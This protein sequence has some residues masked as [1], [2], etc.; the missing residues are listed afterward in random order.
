MANLQAVV[1]WSAVAF[2]VYCALILLARGARLVGRRRTR[3][4]FHYRGP[5]RDH[6]TPT[7]VFI[8]GDAWTERRQAPDASDQL[9]A[10]TEAEFIRKRVMN[11]GEFRVFR[12]IEQ[13]VANGWHG[14]RVLSQTALGEVIESPDRA[15]HAAINSKRA[16]VLVIDS[17]GFPV[18]AVEVQG[19]AH[20]RS[21]AAARDSVKREA[22]RRAGV[23]YLEVMD[24]HSDADVARMLRE[25]LGRAVEQ[26][27]RPAA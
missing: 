23:A 6:H 13:E 4:R 19:K 11:R 15:A 12:V 27:T 3:R 16:D 5:P 8:A 7:P 20:Y 1:L 21:D 14:Y 22:L 18:L 9:R 25:V 26:R 17:G 24:Y 10:V 2:A